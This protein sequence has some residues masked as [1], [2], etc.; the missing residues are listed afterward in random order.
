MNEQEK[1]A[2]NREIAEALGWRAK[3]VVE[4]VAR[5]QDAYW[6]LLKPD[7]DI[8]EWNMSGLTIVG[9]SSESAAYMQ[10]PAY[11]DDMNAG[12][13]ELPQD[14]LIYFSVQPDG[15]IDCAIGGDVYNAFSELRGS[16]ATR[17]E[18]FARALLSWALATKARVT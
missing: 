17:K 8:H 2:L 12:D 7:G 14:A 9:T 16:G 4:N 10:V 3:L 11:A 6:Q 15:T 5:E 1:Q 13:A 18:A